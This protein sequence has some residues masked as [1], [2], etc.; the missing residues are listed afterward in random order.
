[1]VIKIVLIPLA[2]VSIYSIA[3]FLYLIKSKAVRKQF[4]G[5]LL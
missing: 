1:M 4:G 2:Y 5:D 3:W